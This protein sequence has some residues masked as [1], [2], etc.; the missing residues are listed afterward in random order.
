[1]SNTTA[2]VD[3]ACSA[4]VV[5]GVAG[6]GLHRRYTRIG[7][8]RG[9]VHPLDVL[10]DVLAASPN[11]DE[12]VAELDKQVSES[13]E[14]RPVVRKSLGEVYFKR[15]AFDKALTQLK[16]AV[17]LSPNDGALHAKLVETYDALMQPDRAAGQ[18]FAS[19]ELARRDVDLWVKLSERLEKLEQPAEAERARTSLVEMLPSETEGHTKLA[20]IRQTQD[21]WEEA[22]EH[23]RHVAR[24]R[25]LEPAGL[26]G[27]AAAQIHQ[28]QRADA[29]KTLNELETTDWPARF[30]DE[31]RQK[32]MPKLRE[33]WSKLNKED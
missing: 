19:V 7:E 14:D 3:D 10:R 32:Q 25:K 22:V 30:H 18:L 24:L 20:E 12:Y 11:L 9:Q 27:L 17:E 31:L 23:W 2:A 28:K 15:H 8:E 21:R 16:L 29:E 33:E 1:M 26:L 6:D 4:A 13:N 5:W